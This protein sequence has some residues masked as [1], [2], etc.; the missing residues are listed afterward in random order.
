MY[1]NSECSHLGPE[2]LPLKAHTQGK[3]L[4]TRIFAAALFVITE[5]RTQPTFP[6]MENW[7]WYVRIVHSKQLLKK[8]MS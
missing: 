8:R 2:I 6:S 5:D 3:H 7:P 1:P 4:Q